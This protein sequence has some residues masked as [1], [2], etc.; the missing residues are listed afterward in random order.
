MKQKTSGFLSWFYPAT[1]NTDI[2]I[3]RFFFQKMSY[4]FPSPLDD[5]FLCKA[6]SDINRTIVTFR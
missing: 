6:A 3:C 5:T 2:K 1:Y 4:F